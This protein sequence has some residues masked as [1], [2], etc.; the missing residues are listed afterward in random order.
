M[1]Q[2]ALHVAIAR[3]ALRRWDQQACDVPFPI[4][5]P[6]CINAFLHGSLGPDT[7][8][9]PGN[10]ETLSLRVHTE[11]AGRFTRMLFEGARSMRMRAY[12]CGWLS[13]VLA[14][15]EIHP[16]VNDAAARLPE[17]WHWRGPGVRHAAV[18]AGLDGWW[19]ARSPELS[20]LRLR[21]AL[22]HRD[23][24]CVSLAY[25][26][27]YR[28]AITPAEFIASHRRVTH[29]YNAYLYLGRWIG[30]QA[31]EWTPLPLLRSVLSRHLSHD[32]PAL[33]FLHSIRPGRNLVQRVRAGILRHDLWLDRH[34][35]TRCV[36]LPDYDLETGHRLDGWA[37]P[38]FAVAG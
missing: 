21:P 4:H 36:D 20:R 25:L 7:G 29:W 28:D 31:R 26:D 18:E 37:A 23:A 9:F 35:A 14:D 2:P 33:G 22:D 17:T 16:L 38:L 8:F 30:R 12:A 19:L 6:D 11:C 24:P 1:P 10:A 15:V 27:A 34:I 5:D 32:A 3:R 13:H